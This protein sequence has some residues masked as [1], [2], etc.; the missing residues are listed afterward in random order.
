MTTKTKARATGN[1]R[2]GIMLAFIVI[3]IFAITVV[4]LRQG[5]LIQGYDHILRQNLIENDET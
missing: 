1:I 4:K 2:I 3:T 5:S